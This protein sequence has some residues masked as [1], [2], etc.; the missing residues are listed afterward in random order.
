MHLAPEAAVAGPIA[1]I[2][3]GDIIDIDVV[4]Q[5]ISVQLTAEELSERLTDWQAP[6]R[7]KKGYLSIYQKV[8]QQADKEAVLTT[9]E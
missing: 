6:P 1:A 3:D 8:V 9:E 4:N 5:S 2:R 7:R